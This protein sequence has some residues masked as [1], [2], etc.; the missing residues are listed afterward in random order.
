[1]RYMKASSL[2]G[3][4]LLC[5]LVM[6]LSGCASQTGDAYTSGQT[7]Q[8]S[9][10]HMG[11]ITHLNAAYID[12]NPTGV[13]ALGGAVVG[14]VVGSAV[15]SPTWSR[16]G[17]ILMTLGGAVIGAVAGTGVEKTLN[18]KDAL[19]ITVDLDD[20]QTLSIVQELG[21]EERSFAV[22]DRVRVLRGSG[23]SARV[24]R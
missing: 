6:T 9:V 1:M 13:G 3:L 15:G 16:A 23:D 12:N 17:R 5:C 11:T 24:R 21:S 2:N 22:G 8:A 18:N 20:G 19:E 7:R 14:G 10:V 4:A